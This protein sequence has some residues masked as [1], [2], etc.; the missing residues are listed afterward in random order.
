M[1][2]VSAGLDCPLFHGFRNNGNRTVSTALGT[3]YCS[4][5]IE[6]CLRDFT[7]NDSVLIVR[8]DRTQPVVAIGNDDLAI[9]RVSY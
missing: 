3:G 8:V 6:T 2:N 9:G 1:I 5:L 7:G 4:A